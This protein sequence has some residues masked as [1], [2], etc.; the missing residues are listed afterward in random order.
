MFN[1]IGGVIKIHYTYMIL[2][3]MCSEYDNIPWVTMHGRAIVRQTA[4]RQMI[5]L[6]VMYGQPLMA[7]FI[8]HHSNK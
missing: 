3:K 2:C 1:D 7:I 4:C 5:T 6:G 8:T